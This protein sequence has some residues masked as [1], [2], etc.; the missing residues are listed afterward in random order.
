MLTPPALAPD[1]IIA[2]LLDD[3]GLRIRQVTFLPIGADIT[4]AVYRVE[5]ESGGAYLLKL[6]RGDFH[7]VA[8]VAPAFLRAHGVRRVMAPLPATDGRLWVSGQGFNWMLYPFVEGKDGYEAT[9]SDAQWVALGKTL[10]AIHDAALPSD[11]IQR[12]P[13]EEYAPRLRDTVTQF[14]REAERRSY[15]D[16]IAAKLAA[17]WRAERSEI[18]LIVERAGALAQELRKSAPRFVVCHGDLHPGNLLLGADD[19]LS[20]VDWDTVILAPK[21]HD[22]M[23]V[24]SNLSGVW[25]DAR[26]TALFYQGYGATALDPI[27][28]SYYRYER[29]VADLVAY[30]EQIFGAQGSVEDREVGLRQ[31]TAQFLPGNDVAIAHR[32]YQGLP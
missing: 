31:M 10:R 12:L 13:R 3:Y 1:L 21:E 14:A 20:I 26:E 7:E 17:F 28:L 4:A 18:R 19:A 8:A 23:F 30:G 24:G 32:G 16:P 25:D 27:A 9:L 29:I 11:L 6:R 2:R 22:L 5:P 15:G